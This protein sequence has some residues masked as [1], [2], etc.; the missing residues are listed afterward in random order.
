M[1]D[2]GPLLSGYSQHVFGL[3]AA[4]FSILLV[5]TGVAKM[6][7]P[8]DTA[9]AI[10][11]MGLPIHDQVGRL[12]GGVEVIVGFGALSTGFVPFLLAQGIMYA[13]F[14]GWVLLAKMKALPMESCGCLGTPDTPPY[15]GHM[16]VDS[17]AV[18]SSLG[19]ALSGQGRRLFE[20]PPS[21]MAAGLALVV[22]GAALSWVVIGDG[23][24]LYGALKP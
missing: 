7:A 3:T 16:V 12:L 10:R 19:V 14:L 5:V 15:W 11:A 1:I 9:R 6:R 24:R 18:I 21:E 13:A 8:A 4:M 23:A 20:G 17:I 22:L 2:C